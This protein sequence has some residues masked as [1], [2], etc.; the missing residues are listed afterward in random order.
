MTDRSDL[1]QAGSLKLLA[2]TFMGEFHQATVAAESYSTLTLFPD[3]SSRSL[4][5]NLPNNFTAQEFL[6]LL[7]YRLFGAS[8]RPLS[9]PPCLLCCVSSGTLAFATRDKMGNVT[10]M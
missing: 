3:A 1:L 7:S 6:V 10:G 2:S 8:A 9:V 4:F 5:D